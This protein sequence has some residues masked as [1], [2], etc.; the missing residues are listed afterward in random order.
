MSSPTFDFTIFY[1]I[2]ETFPTSIANQDP[3]HR[4]CYNFLTLFPFSFS[5]LNP[6]DLLFL[7]PPV[8]PLFYIYL[9]HQNFLIHMPF[10][11]FL[12]SLMHSLQNFLFNEHSLKAMHS[13]T[14]KILPSRILVP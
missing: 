11:Y 1:D 10:F 8:E 7:S 13:F 5:I 6:A 9:F 2:P 12:H 3:I 4:T 14:I